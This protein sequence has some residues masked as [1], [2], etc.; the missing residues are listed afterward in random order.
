MSVKIFKCSVCGKII[1]LLNNESIPTVCCNETMKELIA[2]T[3][4]AAVEKHVPVVNVNS[5]VIEVSVG[6]VEHPMEEKH[7]IEWILIETE[8]GFQI[9]YLKPGTSPKAQFALTADDKFIKAYAY[10]NLHGLWASK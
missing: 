5:N 9:K 8:K 10:C 7:F 2:G 1:I 6:S 4:D 3:T